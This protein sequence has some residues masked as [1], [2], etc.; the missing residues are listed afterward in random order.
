MGLGKKVGATVVCLYVFRE[1]FN[2]V[3]NIYII[4]LFLISHDLFI[5]F[6]LKVEFGL[7][8]SVPVKNKERVVELKLIIC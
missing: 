3:D 4:L 5:P 6:T 1:T 7:C 2:N 8:S